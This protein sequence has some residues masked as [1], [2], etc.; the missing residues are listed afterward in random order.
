MSKNELV[1][2]AALRFRVMIRKGFPV[3]PQTAYDALAEVTPADYAGSSV[4][5]REILAAAKRM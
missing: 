4:S 3:A 5:A 2:A 1:E